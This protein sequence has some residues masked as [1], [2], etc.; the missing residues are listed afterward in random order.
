MKYGDRVK[1][2]NTEFNINSKL[3]YRMLYGNIVDTNNAPDKYGVE[4]ISLRRLIYVSADCLTL[5]KRQ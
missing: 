5:A 2:D 4:I 1:V 3:N